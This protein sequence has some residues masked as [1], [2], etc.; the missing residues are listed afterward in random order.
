MNERQPAVPINTEQTLP[1]LTD[2]AQAVIETLRG[3]QFGTIE[4]VIHQSRIMQ[5]VRSERMRF[6]DG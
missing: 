2:E 4:I 3:L 5:V 1:P 6:A